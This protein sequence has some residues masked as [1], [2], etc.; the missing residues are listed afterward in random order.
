MCN[1]SRGKGNGPRWVFSLMVIMVWAGKILA[2]QGLIAPVGQWTAYV[3]HKNAKEM[4]GMLGRVYVATSGGFFWYDPPTGFS[5]PYSKVEGLSGTEPSTLYADSASKLL[6]LGF[7]DGMVNIVDTLFGVEYVGDINRSESFTT[8][9]IVSM[10]RVDNL[11]FIAAQFGVVAFDVGQRETRYSMTKIGTNV[12]GAEIKDMAIADGRVWVAMGSLGLWSA[13]F[14]HPVYG[15]PAAWTK[16]GLT[17][18]F[19]TGSVD[20]IVQNGNE[21]YALKGDSIFRKQ[22]GG[23]WSFSPFPVQDYNYLGSANGY[24]YATYRPSF[25]VILHPGDSIE[26]V[27]RQG[28]VTCGYVEGDMVILGD[29]TVGMSRND[30]MGGYVGG[31]PVGPKNNFVTDMAAENGELYIAPRG[32]SGVS[33]RFFDRSGIPYFSLHNGFWKIND[34]RSGALSQNDVWRDF[35]RVTINPA[36]GHAWVGSWGDGIVELDSGK[37]VETYSYRNSG[38]TLSSNTDHRVSG[39]AFDEF[40]NLWIT[41]MLNLFSLNVLTSEGEWHAFNPVPGINPV[42]ITVDPYGNKWIIDQDNGL[43]VFNDNFTPDNPSDDRTRVVNASY[44]NGSLPNNSVRSLALDQD[45]QLWIGTTD[46]ITILYDPSLTFTND[47]QDAACPLIDGYCL[48]RGQEVYDIAVDGA[49]RKW[50]ATNSGVYFVN[51]DGTIL[52]KHFTEDNSPLLSNEVFSVEIDGSTGEVFFG[53]SKGI[54]SYMGDAN[55]GRENADE[56]YTFPNPVAWDYEGPVMIKGMRAFSEVKIA[57]VAGEVVRT[58]KSQGGEVPWDCLD[59]WGRK[60]NPGIYLVFVA[61]PDG[62]GAGISKIAI[63]A[64]PQ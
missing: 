53:T 60:V 64:R 57:T 47:F 2:Q 15:Q 4:A 17:S 25:M 52:L 19:T 22:A 38:L 24:V 46:G 29:A 6:F 12:T 42:G 23:N 63:L 44:G 54:V 30:G 5:V 34:D 13:S 43:V 8:K 56:L 20:E 59:D 7:P 27:D 10:Q 51:V 55:Q 61:D 3:S 32:K 16:E 14:T 39:L 50:I 33:G 28:S 21:L 41:Q 45:L 18:G 1:N 49:N 11:L 58:L 36:D 62:A 35:A 9:G 26:T 48:L 40:G 31:A 37:V